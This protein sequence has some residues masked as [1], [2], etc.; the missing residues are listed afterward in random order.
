MGEEAET[1][2][3]EAYVVGEVGVMVESDAIHSLGV[4]EVG[5]CLGEARLGVGQG[6]EGFMIGEFSVK[7]QT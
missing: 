1:V 6:R 7:E 4:L 3:V 5:I 2:V